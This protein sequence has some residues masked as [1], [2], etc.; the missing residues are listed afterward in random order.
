[1]EES[2][3]NIKGGGYLVAKEHAQGTANGTIYEVGGLGAGGYWTQGIGTFESFNAS[4]SSSSYQDNAPV[5]PLSL[6]TK[7]ILKY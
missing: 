3:P 6:S 7:L 1:M 4:H 5:R 2:L